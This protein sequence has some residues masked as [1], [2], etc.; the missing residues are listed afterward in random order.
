MKREKILIILGVLTALA[1][2]YGLPS[3]YLTII[4]LLYGLSIT[5]IGY[6]LSKKDMGARVD[7]I[8]E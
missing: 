5:Y 7:I 2:F 3:S 4:L 6:T 8:A 1:P